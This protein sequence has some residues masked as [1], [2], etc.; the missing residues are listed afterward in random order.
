MKPKSIKRLRVLLPRLDSACMDRPNSLI[1]VLP[2]DLS[3]LRPPAKVLDVDRPHLLACHDGELVAVNDDANRHSL[4]AAFR[5]P[6]IQM[7]LSGRA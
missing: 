2:G 4:E 7:A 5:T 3:P 6:R 1:R